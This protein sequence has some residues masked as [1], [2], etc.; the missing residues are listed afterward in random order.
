MLRLASWIGSGWASLTGKSSHVLAAGMFWGSMVLIIVRFLYVLAFNFHPLVTTIAILIAPLFFISFNTIYV[1][2]KKVVAELESGSG[3]V[4][5]Q[6]NEVTFHGMLWFWISAI[7]FV[8]LAPSAP[9]AFAHS[10]SVF[11]F[12]SPPKKKQSVFSRAKEKVMGMLENKQLVPVPI[13]V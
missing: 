3:L 4:P 8:L 13:G 7:D 10:L 6:L 9:V 11:M 12:L 1:V 5:I 2:I